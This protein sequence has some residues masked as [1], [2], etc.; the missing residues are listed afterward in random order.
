MCL[1]IPCCCCCSVQHISTGLTAASSLHA[2]VCLSVMHSPCV[3]QQLYA[4]QVPA[5]LSVVLACLPVCMLMCIADYVMP[6]MIIQVPN[7]SAT[8]SCWLAC[9][10]VI[11]CNHLDGSKSMLYVSFCSAAAD[12]PNKIKINSFT[13]QCV[14]ATSTPQIAAA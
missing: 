12:D 10:P 9:L 7:E 14:K 2:C 11:W 3:C 5:C 1:G 4:D 13:C 6:V 8:V